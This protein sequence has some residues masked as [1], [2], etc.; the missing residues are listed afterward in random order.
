MERAACAGQALEWALAVVCVIGIGG[1]NGSGKDEVADYLWERRQISGLE[2]GDVVRRLARRWGL[3]PMR[4]NLYEVSRQMIAWRGPRF[5]MRLLMDRAADCGWQRYSISGVRTPDDVTALRQRHGDG[6]L[7]VFVTVSDARVR[8]E[9]MRRRGR[10]GDPQTYGEFL[11]ADEAAE[12]LF[13]LEATRR[14]ADL[15]LPNDGTVEELHERI[16]RDIVKPVLD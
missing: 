9:R 3:P 5:L 4:R 10:P 13:H 15:Q 11:R 12:A 14:L 8:F 16:E 1:R 6:A 7:M 2:A